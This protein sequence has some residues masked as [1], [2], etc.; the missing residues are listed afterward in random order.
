MLLDIRKLLISG[1]DAGQ[2]VV[3]ELSD[4]QIETQID[5]NSFGL[6]GATKKA[7]EVIRDQTPRGRPIQSVT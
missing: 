4:A 2:R 7:M 3:K 6:I 1:G 5:V